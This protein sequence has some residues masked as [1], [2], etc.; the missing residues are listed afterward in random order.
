MWSSESVPSIVDRLKEIVND[1]GGVML[2]DALGQRYYELFGPLN[3]KVSSFVSRFAK[4]KQ[5]FSRFS[6]FK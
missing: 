5:I 2:V 1:V 6:C 3:L 4:C